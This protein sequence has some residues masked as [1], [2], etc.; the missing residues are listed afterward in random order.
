MAQID[1]EN[2]E[3]LIPF[4]VKFSAPTVKLSR[5]L[6][7]NFQDTFKETQAIPIVR[8]I[9]AFQRNRNLRDLLIRSKLR[10]PNENFK[11]LKELRSAR[12]PITRESYRL[13]PNKPLNTKNCVYVIKC[14][15][16]GK[17]Y[18]GET[19]TTVRTRLHSHLHNI[20]TQK[21]KNTHLV[22]HFLRHGTGS[23]VA[24]VLDHNP[25]W[26]TPDRQ[27]QE[28]HWIRKLHTQ[29]PMG[30]NQNFPKDVK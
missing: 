13:P 6:Q 30:L 23:V 20:R 29:F 16:C 24:M 7:N 2:N 9:T 1:K 27:K 14:K 4:T 26:S 19:G 11:P 10:P 18:V 3:T 25:E 15:K 8:V 21:K 22:A 17:M 12:N 5:A 28:R